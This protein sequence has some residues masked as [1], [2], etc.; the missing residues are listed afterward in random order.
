MLPCYTTTIDS[1][2][3]GTTEN[4]QQKSTC[5]VTESDLSNFN[6]REALIAPTIG[7]FYGI[8]FFFNQRI[9]SLLLPF[10]YRLAHTLCE[11]NWY[12]EEIK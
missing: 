5:Q 7:L 2:S 11:L 10:I 9:V 6:L 1:Q 12:V 3:K 8:R 4:E